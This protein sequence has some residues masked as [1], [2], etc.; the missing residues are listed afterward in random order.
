[1]FLLS[2]CGG[3]PALQRRAQTKQA[4]LDSLLTHA[5]TIGIAPD[6]LQ[7]VIQQTQQLEKTHAPIALFDA[8][9]NSKYYQNLS[10]QYQQLTTRVHGIIA[11]TTQQTRQQAQDSMQQFQTTLKQRSA[12]HL[13]THAFTQ[14]LTQEQKQLKAARYPKDY[15]AITS[16]TRDATRALGMLPEAAAR[17]DTFKQTLDQMNG[18]HLDTSWLQ[19]QYLADEQVLT[20]ATTAADMQHLNGM[21]D[22]QYMQAV[23]RSIQALPYILEAKLKDVA[24]RI[25]LLQSYGGNATVYQKQLNA[26]TT[27]LQQH[28]NMQGY[29]TLSQTIDKENGQL[30][31]DILK[32][33]A[34]SLVEQF[35]SEV[36]SWGSAHMY[37]DT[38]NGQS[39]SLDTG[40]GDPGIGSDLDGYLASAVTPQDF[41][42]V[43]TLANNDTFNLHLFE[44]DYRDQTS[45]ALVHQ[46]DM[47]VLHHY[48]LLR[49]QVIVISLAQQ[50]LR[51]YQNG[52]LV[53]GFQV[54]TGQAALP[55]LPGVWPIQARESPTIFKSSEPKSS[56]YW[57]PDTPI[58]YAI[59]YHAGGYFIHDSWWRVDYGPGTQFPHNDSGGDKSFAGTG[60][61]G[62][63]NV[64]LDQA[65]WLYAN[66]NWQTQVVIY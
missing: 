59:L 40:Y 55:S 21:I 38:F 58:H 33:E 31:F 16:R 51:V 50:A 6:D 9:A 62:C 37:H 3:D 57:Y 60:S 4:Q 46:T 24:T 15:V 61:H 8:S 17:M 34:N 53:R 27:Q 44:A 12:Q 10:K 29:M 39:Y 25:K 18:N 5:Q 56:P 65:A 45:Y 54:T 7:P 63:V 48:N 28:L 52:E 23:V 43:V 36:D 19:D 22:L 42:Q 35:H 47:Q 1:M 26:N 64:P 66:T 11:H 49:G 13:P 20:Q 14:Q 32:S 41:Q 2:A 30:G